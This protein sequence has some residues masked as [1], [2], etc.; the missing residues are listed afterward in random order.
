M[1][2]ILCAPMSLWLMR[3]PVMATLSR[4]LLRN[5]PRKNTPTQKTL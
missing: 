1:N 2:P 3:M 4:T 5:T